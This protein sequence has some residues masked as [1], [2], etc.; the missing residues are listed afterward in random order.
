[1]LESRELQGYWWLPSL[2]EGKIPGTLH[3]S[4]ADIRL[5]LLG[6]FAQTLVATHVDEAE[7][8]EGPREVTVDFASFVAFQPRILGEARNGKAVTLELCNGRSLAT[9]FPRL[10]TSEYGP[11][12]VLVGAWYEPDE[13]VA[14][15]E[16]AIR[17]SD[18]DT[19]ASV[20]GFATKYFWTEDRKSFASIE[21]TFTPPKDIEVALDEETTLRFEFPYTMS[22]MRPVTT[23]LH[24]TQAATIGIAFAAEKPA[25][26]ERSL[27][28]VAV[29]RNFLALAVGRP[30]RVLSVRGFHNP[31][32]DAETDR[33]TGLDPQ[34][35]EVEILYRLVGLPEPAE[36]ELHPT[37]MLFT[38]GQVHPKLEEVLSTWFAKQELL[39]PVLARYFHLVHTPP[40]SREQEFE[41]L[42]RVLETHHRLVAGPAAKT[43]EHL[44]RLAAILSAVPA[45]HREWLGNRLEY[46][47]ESTL[48]QRLK[49][50]LARCP[51]IA[52]RVVGNSEACS[53]F[54]RKVSLTRNYETHLDPGN[55]EEAAQG[56]ELVAL[57]YQLRA[58][59]E[60]TLLL[61]IGFSCEEIAAIFERQD[62][63]YR[64]IE[65][66]RAR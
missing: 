32:A 48:S 42:T 53:S 44:E 25:N 34:K 5:E 47:H 59:V 28:Y 43:T 20:S 45:E 49:I 23:E 2:P 38:V 64:Q 62:V 40:T 55:R 21:S 13:E 7:Q 29:L 30:I 15:D 36:R 1:V 9:G 54:A 31:P 66:L 19:W 50:A 24:I 56:A 10:T 27:T 37:E 60:I 8:G 41:N 3:F 61:E 51:E 46:S 35:L 63:R 11:R 65:A 57:T 58:L 52:T 6:G 26:I 14:F 18:L 16:I 17:F 39:G 12:F 4:Q 33:F 22:G